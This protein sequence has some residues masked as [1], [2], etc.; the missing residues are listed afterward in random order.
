MKKRSFAI[1]FAAAL[2]L[3]SCAAPRNKTAETA[4]AAA[5]L[6]TTTKTSAAA[7]T[8]A[9]TITTT[10]PE[11]TQ[12]KPEFTPECKARIER[13]A[14][15]DKNPTMLS[16]IEYTIDNENFTVSVKL[17]YDNYADIYT[18]LNCVTDISVTGGEYYFSEG[19]LT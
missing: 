2:M 9:A 19:A 13:F 6:A 18:L 11:T 17:T 15:S 1:A 14:I 3:S 8:E 5:S 16:P 12:P 7:S 10:A 4:T